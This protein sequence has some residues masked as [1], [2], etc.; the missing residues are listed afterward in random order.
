M[1]K[2]ENDP[3]ALENDNLRLA[4]TI[5]MM[6]PNATPDELHEKLADIANS[7]SK[8]YEQF[9]EEANKT[10]LKIKE[11]ALTNHKINLFTT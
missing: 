8:P 6:N 3:V 9:L 5:I 7:S 11:Y 1:K 2:H 10:V 4:A